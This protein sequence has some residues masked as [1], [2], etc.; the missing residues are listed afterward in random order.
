MSQTYTISCFDGSDVWS[1]DL[2]AMEDNF[3]ALRT[4]FSGVAQPANA[5]AGMTWY[6][7]TNHILKI[8]DETNNV[9][10]SIWDLANNKPV[11]ANLSAEITGAMIAAAI[12][13]AIP[14]TASLRTLGTGAQQA[15]PGN[16][17][18]PPASSSI[19]QSQLKTTTGSVGGDGNLTLPGGEYGFYPQIVSGTIGTTVIAYIGNAFPLYDYTTNIYLV[20]T[21]VAGQGVAKQRYITASSEDHWIFLLVDK[22]TRKI[23]SAYE[24]PDHP[25]A[26]SQALHIDV[27]HPFGSYDPTK[28]DIVLADND[29]LNE[30]KG[31]MNRRRG[32]LEII[33]QDCIVDD[34]KSADYKVRMIRKINEWPDEPFPGRIKVEMM[35]VPQWVKIMIRPEEIALETHAV[36]RLPAD[37]KYRHLVLK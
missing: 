4:H 11:I 27:P 18:F 28:H 29:I 31:C 10:L 20:S 5:I 17:T 6:D 24:A 1:I 14:T 32:I 30:I 34:A 21:P 23:V 12:K 26:N 37:I 25:S 2:Q 9:W 3:E 36:E 8:R 22:A 7:T 16:T 19:G 13:D 33:R 15:M 35:K